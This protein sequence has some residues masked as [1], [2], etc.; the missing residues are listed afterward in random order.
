MRIFSLFTIAVF[1]FACKPS[2]GEQNPITSQPQ[3]DYKALAESPDIKFTVTGA[4]PG[5]VSLIGIFEGQNYRVDSAMMD[6]SGQVIFKRQEPYHPGFYFLMMADQSSFQVLIDLDQTFSMK[7]LRTDLYNAMQVEGSLDNEL[8][9]Q[10]LKFENGQRPQFDANAQ[11]MAAVAK[12]TPEYQ[13]LKGEQQ[14]LL[15]QRKEFLNGLFEKHPDALFSKFKRAGQNPDLG[16]V[17]KPDGSIDTLRFAWMYRTQFWEGVDFN[18]ERLLYT[19]VISNKLNR[20]IKELTPQHPD[21]INAAA[22]FLISKVPVKSEYFKYFANWVT[23]EYDPKKS[24]LMDAQAIFVH[25]VQTYFTYDKAFWS[26]SVEVH[27]LQL[28]AYEMAASL[29]GKKGPDVV[30]TDPNGQTR[31]IYE[32]KA[33][34]VIVY[35]YNPDCEHCAVET[36]KLVQFY[37]EWK[38]KGVEVFGIAVD[39]DAEKWKAYIAKN[40]MPWVNVFDPTNKSI[41]AKYFVDVTPE[42]YVLDPNRTLIA[43][44]LKVDQIST[45][46]NRDMQKRNR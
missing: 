32:I 33:P 26:D 21:S 34:Y 38:N 43:K 9:Y 30:S 4:N 36:P 24:T 1:A 20:Y 5:L 3:K 10:A 25:M 6:A 16:E 39:T 15:N 13:R 14:K 18:D 45:V 11:Q 17:K 46:L 8:L 40:G 31:S 29:V 28:R 22:D 41:Y 37:K 35:M 23:L 2:S 27:G 44:N 42:I 19:P 7:T 12:G